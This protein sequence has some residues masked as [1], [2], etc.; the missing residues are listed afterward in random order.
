VSSAGSCKIIEFD[1][2]TFFEMTENKLLFAEGGSIKSPY[3]FSGINYHLWKIC[4]KIFIESI[5]Q[6]IWNA[7]MNGPFIPKHI[8]D[9]K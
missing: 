9:D 5:D 4:M 8:V 2:K 7:L 3:M 6:G 1:P